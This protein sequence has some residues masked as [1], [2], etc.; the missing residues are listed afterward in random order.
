[1]QA[2]P[3]VARQPLLGRFQL[4]VKKLMCRRWTHAAC[5]VRLD[6]HLVSQSGLVCSH[7]C[8]PSLLALSC[9]LLTCCHLTVTCFLAHRAEGLSLT[10]LFRDIAES[11]DDQSGLQADARS[12]LLRA[13]LLHRPGSWTSFTWLV[14]P[15]A[16]QGENSLAVSRR[17]G[18]TVDDILRLNPGRGTDC[19]PEASD[20][21]L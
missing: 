7:P 8:S 17:F 18:M 14:L 12:S 4:Q 11:S 3:A 5:Q 15:T 13:S 6:H 2:P 10:L 16:W 19:K 20:L 21:I 9:C 1:M